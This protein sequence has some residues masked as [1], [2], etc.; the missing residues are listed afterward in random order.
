[1]RHCIAG[2]SLFVVFYAQ[3]PSGF[4]GCVQVSQPY[5][6]APATR[7]EGRR[8]GRRTTKELHASVS[9]GGESECSDDT[10]SF[11]INSFTSY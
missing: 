4:R 3:V 7:L 10:I 11:R 6:G 5:P 2:E 8:L 9:G 1:M